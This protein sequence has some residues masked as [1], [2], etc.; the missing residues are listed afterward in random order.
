MNIIHIKRLLLC[1][2]PPFQAL[3]NSTLIGRLAQIS[4]MLDNP[5]EPP[6]LPNFKLDLVNKLSG[7]H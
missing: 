1:K 6:R 4:E 2:K 7:E 3:T 5:L